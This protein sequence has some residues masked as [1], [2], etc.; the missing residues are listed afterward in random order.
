V[1]FYTYTI[2]YQN[3][4]VILIWEVQTPNLPA[5]FQRDSILH[6]GYASFMVSHIHHAHTA[7]PDPKPG[8]Y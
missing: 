8:T 3:A 4:I 1:L 5:R 6:T 2:L 7:Q